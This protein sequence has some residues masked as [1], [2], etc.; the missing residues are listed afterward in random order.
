V[1]FIALLAL[2]LAL[3]L[4]QPATASDQQ[5]PPSCRGTNMLDEMQGT[6]PHA[7][8]LA[9]A[10]AA[11]NSSALLWRIERGDKP[12]SYLFGTVHLTD[13]RVSDHSSTLKAALAGSR[14]LVLEIDDLSPGSFMK[15][16]VRA[17]DL[18]MFRDGR[19][20][21]QLL[22]EAEYG[23]VIT[24]LQRAGLPAE[25][26]G[27]FRPWVASMML[28]LSE[29]EQLRMQRGLLPL[30][31]QL[32]RDAQSLGIAVAGL[33]TLELQLRA[34]AS[35]PEAD[36]IDILRAGLRTYE[37]IDDILETT[38]QLYLA[39]Q[40]GAIWPLQLVLAERAG[41]AAT[42][43]T[44]LEQ[45][46]LSTRNLGMRESA[47]PHLAEGGAFIAVGA[48]HLPGRQGLVSLLREAG[49][50]LTAVE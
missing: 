50:T 2:G 8:I 30:D 28:A 35:V 21:D 47:A 6:E 34:M 26:A 40:L 19:R 39:R 33:E 5:A 16:F 20:L 42:A 49:Y 7:R 23:K 18:M 31:A 36:Q 10:A 24:I 43:F 38:V 44:A 9:A 48:L 46:L 17:R 11:E 1:Q 32:A 29:C 4:G 41:V 14:R 25:I 3:L 45:S 22:N 12:A 37:R 27:G 15:A 13:D